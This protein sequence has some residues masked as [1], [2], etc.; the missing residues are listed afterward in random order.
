MAGMAAGV[1]QTFIVAPVELLKVRQQLQTAV[2]GDAAYVGPVQL[3][4]QLL[5]AEGVR[6]EGQS[7]RPLTCRMDIP[8]AIPSSLLLLHRNRLQVC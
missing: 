1:V 5:R 4:R 8:V 7:L 3:L 2:A 6:G